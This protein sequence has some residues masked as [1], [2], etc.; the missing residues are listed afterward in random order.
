MLVPGDGEAGGEDD[1][2]GGLCDGREE[3]VSG[4][5]DSADDMD[6]ICGRSGELGR[7]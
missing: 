2:Y 7:G 4:E 1:D 6:T 5:V 3:R